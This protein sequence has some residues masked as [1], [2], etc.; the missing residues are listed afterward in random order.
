[1]EEVMVALLGDLAPVTWFRDPDLPKP[2]IFVKRVGGSAEGVIDRPIVRVE[3]TD[4][5]RAGVNALA[6][7]VRTRI[8]DAGCTSVTI[9]VD[10][11]PT[12]VLID[13]VDE[14][15][16]NQQSPYFDPDD[17]N[18]VSNYQLSFRPL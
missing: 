11:I 2:Y 10:D 4:H 1:M 12:R 3:V 5:D 9:P 8:L 6:K 7:S 14:R 18:I 13:T 15:V 16:A 17:R